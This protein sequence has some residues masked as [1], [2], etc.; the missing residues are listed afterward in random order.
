MKDF[1][2][3]I[4]A[5]LRITVNPSTTGPM[6]AMVDRVAAEFGLSK[7]VYH[8]DPLHWADGATIYYVCSTEIGK[9]VLCYIDTSRTRMKIVFNFVDKAELSDDDLKVNGRYDDI[10]VDRLTEASLSRRI[11]AALI[12]VQRAVHDTVERDITSARDV[13]ASLNKETTHE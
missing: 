13:L 5:W 10:P 3:T 7:Q 8:P 1:F 2:K 6:L 4:A 9:V 11:T 12:S